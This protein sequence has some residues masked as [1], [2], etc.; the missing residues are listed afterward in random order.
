MLFFINFDEKGNF[1][2]NFDHTLCRIK[3]SFII[4][5]N[6]MHKAVVYRDMLLLDGS[7]TTKTQI[8]P[9]RSIQ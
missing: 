3:Q 2:I 1:D 7:Q 4:F 9:Y 5:P 8:T 6:R